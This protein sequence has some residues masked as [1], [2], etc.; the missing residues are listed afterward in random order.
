M[1]ET[2][3]IKGADCWGWATWKRGW[4]LFEPNGE[5]LLAEIKKRNLKHRFDFYGAYAYFQMLK[6]QIAGKNH[7]WAVR[8]YASA[9][10]ANKLTLYPGRS[11]VRNIGCDD[12]GRHCSTT[13]IYNSEL[14]N[15]E[16]TIG[17]IEVKEDKHSLEKISNWLKEN[18]P[19]TLQRVVR[20]G[21]KFLKSKIPWQD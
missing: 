19:G 14:Q 17:D 7:S 8:W 6:D 15:I 21:V 12:T 11:L 13:E 20:K 3:F 9:L 1:P 4:D 16:I 18:H 5:K 10:L 2:F